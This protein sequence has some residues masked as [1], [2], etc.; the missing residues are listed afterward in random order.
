[1][2]VAVM[3]VNNPRSEY[4]GMWYVAVSEKAYE[5]METV[6]RHKSKKV[7]VEYAKALTEKPIVTSGK[8]YGCKF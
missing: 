2:C 4:N 8:E 3:K 5:P 6:F 7:C 1:M